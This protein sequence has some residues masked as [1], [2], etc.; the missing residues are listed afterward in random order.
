MKKLIFTVVSFALLIGGVAYAHEHDEKKSPTT[1]PTTAPTTKP[2]NKMC[3]VNP[4]D[5]V[6]DRVSVVYEGK[7]IGF[8]CEDCKA[9]FAK[10][11]KSYVA[12]L[13]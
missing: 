10:D 13:K 1:A 3:A 6:D 8:C 4:E 2:V 5:P 12:K 7:V 11:P 9:D